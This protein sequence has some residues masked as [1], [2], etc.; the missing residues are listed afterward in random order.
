MGTRESGTISW[1]PG[2][3]DA[4]QR[5]ALTLRGLGRYIRIEVQREQELGTE[6]PP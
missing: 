2:A 1:S 5:R 6:V 4:A 3:F